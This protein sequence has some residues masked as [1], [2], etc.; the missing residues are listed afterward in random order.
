MLRTFERAVGQRWDRWRELGIDS[1]FRAPTP[2]ERTR[3]DFAA[4]IDLRSDEAL[5]GL[6]VWVSGNAELDVGY[7]SDGMVRAI[8]YEFSEPT[9]V[10]GALDELTDLM[11]HR[12]PAEMLRP[13]RPSS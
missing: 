10:E 9:E 8:H 7:L 6:T 2:E 5:G 3:S 11:L 4:S 13:L 1:T 12:P